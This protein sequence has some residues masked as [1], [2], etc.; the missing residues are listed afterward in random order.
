MTT[1]RCLAMWSGPRNI[2][3]AMMRAWEN[4]PDTQVVDEPF[5]AHYLASTGLDHPLADAIIAEGETDWQHIVDTLVM[6]PATGFL[7][8]KH[9]TVHWL[10]HFTTDWLEQLEHVF[11]IRRP[12]PVIAS[13]IAKRG[14]VDATDLG[15]ARQAELFDTIS[16][17]C[18]KTPPVL[19]SDLF[20]AD[21]EGQLRV[22]CKRL[23]IAFDPAMLAWP[24]GARESDGLWGRHWYD[25]VNRSTG[26]APPRYSKPKSV[27]AAEK[28]LADECR[29]DYE[30]LAE[31]A[32][33]TPSP[34]AAASD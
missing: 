20:L 27:S 24:A 8:Q 6:R 31:H 14:T 26:F 17:R 33:R 1:G 28:R 29:P 16:A 4:R 25:A 23:S 11:L 3:T 22:L 19:D 2:S 18:G 34:P 12:D 7:Y 10:D 9:M 32:I 5:Y 21:P 13:Y 15:Y 30:R